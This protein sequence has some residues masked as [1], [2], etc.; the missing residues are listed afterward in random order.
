VRIVGALP[1]EI[2]FVNEYSAYIPAT[3]VAAESAQALIAWMA[4]PASR[5]VFKAAG[6]GM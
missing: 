1:T 5:E 2:A 6:A 4:R 3:S